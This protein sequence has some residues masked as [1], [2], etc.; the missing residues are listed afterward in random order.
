MIHAKGW[1]TVDA[2]RGSVAGSDWRTIG[3]LFCVYGFTYAFYS[4]YGGSFFPLFMLIMCFFILVRYVSKMYYLDN[5]HRHK[6]HICVHCLQCKLL[7]LLLHHLYKYKH[8]E[9]RPD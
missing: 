4:V 3:M 7:K 2:F 9:Y 6:K 5:N 8:F 1:Q